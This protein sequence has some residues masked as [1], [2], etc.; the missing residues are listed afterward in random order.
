M[1]TIAAISLSKEL[2]K[3]GSFAGLAAFFGFAVLTV[4]YFAQAREVKR[5]REWAGRA[6]ERANELEHRV[7]AAAEARRVRAEPMRKA[8]AVAATP[9]GQAAA[10]PVGQVATQGDAAAATGA[11]IVAAAG[12]AAAAGAT[13]PP[14]T[15]ATPGAGD[16]KPV[17]SADGE[18]KTAD[19]ATVPDAAAA[20]AAGEAAEAGDEQAD[21]KSDD[22]VVSTNGT[23]EETP[24]VPPAR[25]TPPPRPTP[26]PLP[27]RRTVPAAPLRSTRPTATPRRAGALHASRHEPVREDTG[28]S[29]GRLA[30]ISAGAVAGVL[31]IGIVLTQLLGGGSDA[32]LPPNQPKNATPTAT[33]DSGS[34]SAGGPVTPAETTVAVLNGTTT[35]GLAKIISERLVTA[36]FG[37]GVITNFTDSQRSA[38]LIFYAPDK[39]AAAREVSKVLKMTGTERQPMNQEVQALSSGADVVVVVGADQT[40]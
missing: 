11:A 33:P 3:I 6:P 29:R 30:A 31:V 25:A 2:E 19:G 28:R 20:A 26:A 10:K 1:L 7:V 34:T 23:S 40:P 18:A 39:A 8:A 27:P 32:P 24:V 14:A 12:G 22:T 15:P 17:D 36:G 13:A 5:L 37:E 21:E 35:A 38:S 4:L 16:D 9:A